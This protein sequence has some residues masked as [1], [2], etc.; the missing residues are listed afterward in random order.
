[1]VT[2]LTFQQLYFNKFLQEN[3]SY[4]KVILDISELL[5][6]AYEK[7]STAPDE[8][9]LPAS[10]LT[11]IQ[12]FENCDLREKL[13][14]FKSSFTKHQMFIMSYIEQFETILLYIRASTE[15]LIKYFFAHDHLNYAR[16]LPVYL[17]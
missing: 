16:L 3:P 5:Q 2:I 7:S 1:M 4:H 10:L 17:S 15:A 9:V 13:V 12:L 11:V 8:S 6:T 14:Y